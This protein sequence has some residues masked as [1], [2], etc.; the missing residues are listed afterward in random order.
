M[1]IQCI[2]L[3]DQFLIIIKAQKLFHLLDLLNFSLLSSNLLFHFLHYTLIS[4]ELFLK[5]WHSLL[6]PWLRLM[7]NCTLIQII[8]FQLIRDQHG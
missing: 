5:L 1:F 4:S 7:N 6:L 3:I 8:G 2:E